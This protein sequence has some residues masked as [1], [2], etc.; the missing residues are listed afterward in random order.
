VIDI[1]LSAEMGGRLGSAVIAGA[2]TEVLDVGYYLDLGSRSVARSA[3][4]SGVR[5][6]ARVL[7]VDDSAFFRNMLRPLLSAAGYEVS[8]ATSAEEALRLREEGQQFDLIL[9]DIEMP[10]LSGLD[11][12][13]AVR[14]GGTW[15]QT[16]M[17]ALSSLAN[18]VSKERGREAGF[19]EY[20][21]KFDRMSL[22]SILERRLLEA[23]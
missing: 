6:P 10:G 22:L 17:I 19:D 14:V 1:R 7:V 15:A 8:V 20:V 23:A 13:Q 21:A 5:A 4:S 11:F 2:V 12:A 3:G 9:S 18:D 16:P